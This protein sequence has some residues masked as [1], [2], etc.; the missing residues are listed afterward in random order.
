MWPGHEARAAGRTRDGCEA[1]FVSVSV[2]VVLHLIVAI[3]DCASPWA[4]PDTRPLSI[5]ELELVS[6]DR[7]GT[8]RRSQV[9]TFTTSP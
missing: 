3:V 4:V 7:N 8:G 1:A 6:S 9:P 5:A 2:N